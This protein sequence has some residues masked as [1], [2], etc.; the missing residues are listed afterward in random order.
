MMD[1]FMVSIM[2]FLV[3]IIVARIINDRA[4]KKLENDKKV[5]LIDLF[6]R[7]SVLTYLP[8]ILIMGLYFLVL[9]YQVF[10]FRVSLSVYML[11]LLVYIAYN[12]KKSNEKLKSADFPASFIKSYLLATSIRFFGILLFFA[13]TVG[14]NISLE[15]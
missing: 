6:S 3:S 8:L 11:L 4:I 12:A 14:G 13:F 10:D 1:N 15:F 9:K 7:S 5:E 2:V